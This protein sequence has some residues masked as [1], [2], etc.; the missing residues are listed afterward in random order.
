MKL[1][2]GLFFFGIAFFIHCAAPVEYVE[3]A[4]IA[5]LSDTSRTADYNPNKNAYFGD[6]HIHTSWS[7]DAFIYNVRTTPD[8]AYRHGKGESIP[9]VSGTNVQRNHPL[10]F[11]AVTDHAEYLGVMMQLGDKTNPLSK[12]DFAQKINSSDPE[13]AKKSFGTLGRGIALNRP[14]PELIKT[15]ILQNTWKKNIEIADKHYQPGKFT[16]FA[17][18]E[19]TSSQGV[20]LASPQY[21]RNMHRNVIFKGGKVSGV[22]FS[23]F[24][25]QDPEDLWK[26]MDAQRAQGIELL[27]IPHNAN[28]SNGKMYAATDDSGNPMT[29]AYAQMRIR[30]EPISEV[31]Q[32]KG[33]SMTH[34]AL[35]PNDEF[36][37]FE[38]YQ[39]T[40][41][42]SEPRKQSQPSGGFV[43]QALKNGLLLEDKLGDN[44]F[45]F[46]FIGSSDGHNGAS[47]TEENNNIGKSGLQDATPEVRLGKTDANKRNRQVA[48]AGLAG[49]WAEENTREAIFEA[50]QRKETFATS[51]SRIKVR[52]FAG[53]GI[54]SINLNQPNWETNAYENGVPMGGELF[55]NENNRAPTFLFTAIKDPEGANLD[56]IQMIK[57]WLDI[58]GVTHEKIFDIAWSDDRPLDSTNKLSPV[59]TTVDLSTATYTNDIGSITLQSKWTDPSFDAKV[60]AFYYLRVLEIPTPRHTTYDAVKLGVDLPANLPPTIQERAWTSPIWYSPK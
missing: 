53:W 30:N 13:V 5:S 24:N 59:G 31:A 9:H 58:D 37:N 10:D 38:L 15:E 26:W 1:F 43:R 25:S 45:K 2:K 39:H 47:N 6:L 56:R 44:P 21:A 54:D 16:T 46:G 40:L 52:C 36:A 8:D 11:M 18:Y 3:V 41:G 4:P 55:G 57:G 7:F 60:S 19:W 20:M 22:P 12:L 48:V 34:P 42:R 28:I 17:G 32:I 50:I 29:Q 49:V 27:A 51:G 23:S 35:S 33:Q 14:D